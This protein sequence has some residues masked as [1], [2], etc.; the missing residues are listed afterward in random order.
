MSLRTIEHRDVPALALLLVVP[1]GAADDPPDRPG[2]AALT[3]DLLDEG[4]G[5]RSSIDV[6]DAISRIGGQFDSE[7]GYDVTIVTLVTLS[8]FR[9][10]AL[11]LLADMVFRPRLAEP[12]FD[13]V[14][15]LR[16]NRLKQL[17]DIPAA[18]A[19]EAFA[20][21]LFG[22]D[23]YGHLP[24][25]TAAALESMSNTDAHAFHDRAYRVGRGVLVAVGDESHA[26]IA[27]A[28]ERAFSRAANESP[29]SDAAPPADPSTQPVGPGRRLV[30][31][32]R[33]GAPQSELRVGRLGA[34]RQTP[35]YHPLV[36]LNNVLGGQFVSR[37]NLNLR[38]EKGYTYGVRSTFEF[39]RRRGPFVV[40]ASVQTEATAEAV[41]EVLDEVSAIR[42]H[43]PATPAELELA[44]ASLTR[45]YARN[46]ETAEQL[47]RAV[48]QQVVHR[49]P[50]DY[51]DT[52]VDD[53]LAVDTDAVTRA[54]ERWLDPDDM[55]AVVVG[56]RGKVEHSL[57]QLGFGEPLLQPAK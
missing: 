54:A 2:L 16:L 49:L 29:S 14:R 30:I 25:G 4:T 57:G 47:A 10:R 53:V 45:G 15:T 42:G 6:H 21:H 9:D 23:P 26:S 43:R 48:A 5:N 31:I 51:F 19:E 44:R 46:F 38:E 55:L 56:D 50:D 8:R 37:I 41:H 1:V 40:Q 27:E 39:R 3:A 13:R 35:D 11:D 7:T 33:P 52:F 12:D 18:L 36:V 22:S 17:R 20:R 24:I 34:A 32:D 28:A